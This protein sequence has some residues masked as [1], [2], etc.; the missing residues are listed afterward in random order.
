MKLPEH[1]G[2]HCNQTHVDKTNFLYL[3]YKY[4]IKS[5]IDV[6]CGPG[7]MVALGNSELVTSFGIDGDFTLPERNN[8]VVHDFTK[9]VCTDQRV[10]R[11]FDLGWS[12]E[13]LEHVEEQYVDNFMREFEKCKYVFC[14][15][16]PPN[17]TGYHHVNCKSLEYWITKFME[18]GFTYSKEETDY[19][20]IHS[21]MRKGFY[22]RAGMF[23]T[24]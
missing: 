22:K 19:M 12:V 20:K 23:Y 14:T 10:N 16:A 18:I 4:D 11:Q 21:S 24:R 5:M 6:G 2:G 15:A 17:A 9:G 7:G 8:I 3:K 1:L 13:F